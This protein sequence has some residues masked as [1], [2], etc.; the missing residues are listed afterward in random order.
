MPKLASGAF[1]KLNTVPSTKTVTVSLVGF[2]HTDERNHAAA[3]AR[4]TPRRAFE[5]VAIE[6]NGYALLELPRCPHRHLAWGVD[7]GSASSR[8]VG[9]HCGVKAE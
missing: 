4:R 3:M 5:F 9:I 1:R 2:S 8:L 6:R 7:G